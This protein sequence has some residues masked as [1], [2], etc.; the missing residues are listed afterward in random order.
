[1]KRLLAIVLSWLALSCGA[2]A[3]VSGVGPMVPNAAPGLLLTG[4]TVNGQLAVGCVTGCTPPSPFPDSASWMGF[5]A[6]VSRSFGATWYD[7]LGTRIRTFDQSTGRIDTYT[8][9]SSGQSVGPPIV[10]AFDNAAPANGDNLGHFAFRGRDTNGTFDTY[11]YLLGGAATVSAAGMNSTL[12]LGVMRAQTAGAGNAQPNASAILDGQ[13]AV[14][15]TPS[16]F[17]FSATGNSNPFTGSHTSGPTVTLTNTTNSRVAVLGVVDNFN[18]GINSTGGGGILLQ[19]AGVTGIS[20]S[21]S[22]T[23]RVVADTRSAKTINYSVLNTDGGTQFDNTGAV[24]EVDFTLPAAP[25]VGTKFGFMVFAAQ[26]VKMIA[27]A[28]TTIN[29]GGTVSA[30]AGNAT[31]SQVGAYVELEYVG[32]NRYVAKS[33]TGTGGSTGAGGWTVT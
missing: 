15:S 12:T 13:N 3:Q 24:A 17:A 18:A 28:S 8:N 7:N 14:F 9:S 6:P 23:T 31:S 30:A 21:A 1:M 32:S 19:S 25:T 10:V 5:Q 20:I 26:I 33:V 11:A 2:M 27:P 4:G 16:G 22:G 29:I